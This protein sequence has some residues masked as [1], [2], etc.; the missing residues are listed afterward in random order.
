MQMS[1]YTDL[2]RSEFGN[3]IKNDLF[4]KLVGKPIEERFE[5]V[6]DFLDPYVEAGYIEGFDTDVDETQHIF[7]ITTY[8]S[9]ET[10]LLFRTA[11]GVIA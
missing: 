4:T 9:D 11:E 8:F 6:N 3:I 7:E 1:K 2:D 5:I 10:S